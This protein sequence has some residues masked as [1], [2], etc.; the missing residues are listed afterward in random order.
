MSEEESNE[1]EDILEI[2]SG[3]VY[4]YEVLKNFKVWF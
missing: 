3:N 1:N 4:V 2:V